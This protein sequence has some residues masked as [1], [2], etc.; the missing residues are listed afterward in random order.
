MVNSGTDP[1]S[2]APGDLDVL[3]PFHIG[4]TDTGIIAFAGRSMVRLSPQLQL[5]ANFSEVFEPVR[6]DAPG[7][8]IPSMLSTGR[9]CTLREKAGGA[10]LRGQMHRMGD[11]TVFL[12]SPWLETTDELQRFGLT[13]NDFAIHDPTLDLLQVVQLNKLVVDDLQRLNA[14]LSEQRARLKAQEAEARKLALIAA[15]T[16][17][18]V[19]LTDARGC[20]EWV[21]DGFTRMTEYGIED[22][23]GRTPGS[24]LQG[25]ETDPATIQYMRRQLDLKQSFR[26]ELV[27]YSKTGRVYWLAIEVQPIF[28]EMGEV[29]NFMAIQSDVTSRRQAD[30]DLR[31][32][33]E[34]GKA[35][36]AASTSMD[37]APAVVKIVGEA[38]GW[39][40]VIFWTMDPPAMQLEALSTWQ[41]GPDPDIGLVALLR[42]SE[43]GDVLPGRVW[44]SR[45]QTWV[46]LAE[47]S[48]PRAGVALMAGLKSAVALPVRTSGEVLGVLEF[49]SRSDREPEAG[50]QRTLAAVAGQLAQFIERSRAETACR[51]RGAE[52]QQVNTQLAQAMKLKDA[53]LASMGHELKTP[54]TGILGLSETLIEQVYGALNEKQVQYLRII[55]GSG[56]KLLSLLTDLLDLASIG[57]GRSQVMCEPVAIR[58]ICESGLRLVQP[59]AATRGQKL[60]VQDLS[61]GAAANVDAARVAHVLEILLGNAAKFTPENGEFGLRTRVTEERVIFEVWDKG[62][63]IAAEDHP[64]LFQPFVQLDDRLARR[65]PGAGLGLALAKEIVHLHGGSIRVASEIGA[66]SCFTVELPRGVVPAP[67]PDVSKERLLVLLVDDNPV[68][69]IALCDYLQHNGCQVEL[70]EDGAIAVEKAQALRPDIVLMDVQMPVMDGLEATRRIRALPDPVFAALPILVVTALTVNGDRELCLDAGATDYMGKPVSPR[71]VWTRVQALTAGRGVRQSVGTA[72]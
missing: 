63:G 60:V 30:E 31:T 45:E 1:V 37:G 66:G 70:A 52:L 16:D 46:K 62:P 38:M 54:L 25:P 43:P 12:G 15:R 28:N 49:F 32:Q 5:G 20:V 29:T 44:R 23:K 34:V 65:Y 21:N 50:R 33:F 42:T 6:Y 72:R 48:D 56:R 2:L 17:N 58:E 8:A 10:M 55:E 7:G 71:A 57:A 51:Q 35:L 3:F 59:V 67:R 27:N 14:R 64:K 61:A 69:L 68:N 22:V 11:H 47:T 40:A 9:L 41:R 18:A 53:F 4:I 24:V 36:A 26:A 13:I 19:V 39:E